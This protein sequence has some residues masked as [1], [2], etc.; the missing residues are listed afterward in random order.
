MLVK[1]KESA[2]H[3]LRHPPKTPKLFSASPLDRGGRE[4]FAVDVGDNFD[5]HPIII[6]ISI[7]TPAAKYVKIK[8]HP[9]PTRVIIINV[10]SALKIM[11]NKKI[12][13]KLEEA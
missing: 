13:N 1:Y 2:C 11:G 3:V 12:Y 6:T 7:S 4:R 9:T 10:K 8:L 5:K